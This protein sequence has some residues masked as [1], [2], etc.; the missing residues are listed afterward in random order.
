[1]KLCS[2]K[3]CTGCTSCVNVCPRKAITIKK[4]ERGFLYPEID[5]NKCINCG[6]CTKYIESLNEYMKTEEHCYMPFKAYACKNK[7]DN[8]R[9]RSQ[10]G[11]LF[12]TLAEN[13]LNNNGVVF[14]CAYDD[15]FH[16]I[17]KRIDN[18]KN[19]NQLL[20]SK[21][22]Q[23]DLKNCISEIIS[24]IKNNRMVLFSGTP[25]QVAGI[26]SL[27]KFKKINL[28]NFYTCDFICHGVPSPLL[29]EKYLNLMENKYKSQIVEVN[30]RD[31]K[32]GGWRNHVNSI[33][34]KNGNYIVDKNYVDLFYSNLGLRIS[35][36][37]CKYTTLNRPSDITMGDCWGIE[38]IKN[39]LWND[40]KGISLAL[41]QTKKGER[42]FNRIKENM[43]LYQIS[44]NEYR[45]PQ[46]L[47]SSPV[48]YQ[49][50]NFWKDIKNK[51][52]EKVLKKYTIY[53]GLKF[54]LRRKILK[55]M[56]RW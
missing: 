51:K 16:V 38:K 29:Y 56:K 7:N 39:N 30:L 3:N 27:L 44:M 5:N 50:E 22:V 11:G 53:G 33:K 35:C 40:N 24:D 52:F 25:C 31:K 18:I 21:Y 6:L 20:G 36:E 55:I 45:Q 49:K 23:S 42:L 32:A 15:D 10:S 13:F 9:E 2:K 54:K 41:I 4:D 28:D 14:G 47:H 46:M 17:H 12:Y 26:S 48:P 8:I 1:M 43:D 34:F 37:N 19:L